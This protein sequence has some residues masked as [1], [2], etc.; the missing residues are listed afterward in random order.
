MHVDRTHQKTLTVYTVTCEEM[1]RAIYVYC[2]KKYVTAT[3]LP[4]SLTKG[5]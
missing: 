3:P 2:K 1:L 5:Q 4:C